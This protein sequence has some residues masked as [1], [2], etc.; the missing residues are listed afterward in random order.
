[1][2]LV[3][4]DTAA[5]DGRQAVLQARSLMAMLPLQA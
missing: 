3:G 5:A 1:V 2:A 4:A